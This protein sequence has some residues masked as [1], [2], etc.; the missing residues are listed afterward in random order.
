VPTLILFL[1]VGILAGS[2]GL[3]RIHFDDLKIAQFIGIVALNFI[4]FSGGFET[5]WKTIKP[6]LGPGIALSTLGVILTA[7]SLGT[8]VW[9]VT[10]FSI[11]DVL[12][13]GSIVSSADAAAVFA[14]LRLKNMGLIGTLR[15]AL[16]LESGING[17]TVY[18]LT[19]VY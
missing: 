4:L 13:L 7:V 14:I 8:L 10:D 18:F 16:E 12:L 11:I 6:V 5:D 19:I 1:L 3:G 9:A 15:P 2:E 17:P